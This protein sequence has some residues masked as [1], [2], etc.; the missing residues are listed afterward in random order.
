MIYIVSA[1]NYQKYDLND[2]GL[3]T[4]VRPLSKAMHVSSRISNVCSVEKAYITVDGQNQGREPHCWPDVGGKIQIY[5]FESEVGS[6]I[7]YGP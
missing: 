3:I 5:T 4:E 6:R 7:K 1:K 2:I